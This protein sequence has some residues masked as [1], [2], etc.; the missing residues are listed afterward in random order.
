MSSKWQSRRRLASPRSAAAPCAAP[1]CCP[2]LAIMLARLSFSDTPP[3]RAHAAWRQ[4]LPSSGVS[5][6][7]NEEGASAKWQPRRRGAVVVPDSRGCTCC[8]SPS[9]TSSGACPDARP[10]SPC[11]R[12][13]PLAGRVLLMSSFHRRSKK[14]PGPIYR[15]CKYSAAGRPMVNPCPPWCHAR[16]IMWHQSQAGARQAGNATQCRAVGG[17]AAGGPAGGNGGRRGGENSPIHPRGSKACAR[18]HVPAWPY[19]SR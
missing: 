18:V 3:P 4:L 15:R 8:C 2:T 17:L 5:T 13:P 19:G 9:G 11:T 12:A 1:S 14:K 16:G 10:S 7:M 6:Q